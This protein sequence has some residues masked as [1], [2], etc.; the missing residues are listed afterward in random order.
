MKPDAREARG[1]LRRCDHVA[2][3]TQS[4]RLPGFPFVSHAPVAHDGSGRLL[5]L[6]S[7]LAEHSR[8]LGADARVSVMATLADGDPQAQPRVT[9]LGELKSVSPTPAQQ[10]RYLRFHPESGAFLGFGDFR[11][12][13]LEPVRVRMVG[14]FARAGW[15]EPADWRC[16]ALDERREAVLLAEL[17]AAAEAARRRVLG[18]DWEGLDVRDGEG[19]RLR[20]CWPVPPVDETE[21]LVAARS[22]LARAS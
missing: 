1:L 8:N 21:L 13:R 5:L 6:L 19:A 9:L 18:L 17:D 10:D 3:A 12:Y 15:I 16:R 11:F 2:L 7:R 4:L 22:A 20:L 14:G